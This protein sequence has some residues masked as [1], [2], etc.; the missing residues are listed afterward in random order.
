MWLNMVFVGNQRSEQPKKVQ[1][2][3]IIKRLNNDLFIETKYKIRFINVRFNCIR[4]NRVKICQEKVPGRKCFQ[5]FYILP[6]E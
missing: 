4:K 6:N 2:E 1:F 3:P 5:F